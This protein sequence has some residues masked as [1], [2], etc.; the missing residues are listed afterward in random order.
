MG[1]TDTPENARDAGPVDLS[2]LTDEALMQRFRTGQASAFRLLMARHGD[3]IHSFI[4]RQVRLPETANDL[5]QEVFLRVVKNADGFRAEAKFT[6]WIYT[7][8][9]N[10]CVDS[11]RRGKHRNAVPLDAPL[12][13][14][15][16]D[17]ATMLDFVKD[18]GQ[19]ADMRL[20]DRR[21]SA[22]L[23]NALGG[24]PAEQR[25]VFL[26]RELHGLKFREIADLVGV[27]ENTVKSRMR[28]ALEGLRQRL[29]KHGDG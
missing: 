28:Y 12:R 4:L 1:R 21:F 17:G 7:I 29:G 22:D 27:P 10:L 26:M 8:A 5:V 2:T 14:D 11:L 9:R 24:I 20:A 23:E 6:T 19:G 15:E 25:E 16:G 13:A 3:K 18:P